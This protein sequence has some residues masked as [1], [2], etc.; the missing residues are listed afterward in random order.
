M[1]ETLPKRA[2]NG[3]IEITVEK[4]RM[5]GW[6]T[7]GLSDTHPLCN[8]AHKNGTEFRSLKFEAEKDGTVWLCTCKQTKKP[9][10]CDGSHKKT[11]N[12]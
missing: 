9:P 12:A 4:G 3:P 7:C 5:Y 2:G 11:D 8:G 6:C 1:S 10:Y